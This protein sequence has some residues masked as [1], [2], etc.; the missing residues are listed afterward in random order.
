MNAKLCQI[1]KAVEPSLRLNYSINH[2]SSFKSSVSLDK[3]YPNSS[4]NVAKPVK[5]GNHP[6]I[7]FILFVLQHFIA[8]TL[9]E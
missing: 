5:V 3:L 7:Y 1:L 8:I 6:K 9:C 4:L 2:F